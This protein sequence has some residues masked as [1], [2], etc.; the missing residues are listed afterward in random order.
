MAVDLFNQTFAVTCLDFQP[1]HCL[2]A[3]L[4]PV[5]L[6]TLQL[7]KKYGIITTHWFFE[8]YRKATYW[9]SVVTGYD[10]FFAIQR[11]PIEAACA[12]SGATYHFLPTACSCADLPFTSSPRPY[13][14]VFIGIPSSYRVAVLEAL[15]RNGTKLAIAGSGWQAYRGILEPM[16]VSTAWVHEE[17]SFALMQQSKTGVNLS[18]DNP[19]GRKDV[20]ISPRVYDMFA[21]GCLV[22]GEDV[23]LLNETAPGA[24]VATFSS[25]EEAVS[26]IAG[27]LETYT[28]DDE[29]ILKNRKLVLDN[30]RYVHRVA[31]IMRAAV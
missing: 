29:R 5:T 24:S 10:H 26:T 17:T 20:H 8:D 6:F 19:A 18:F 1:T 21:A 2:V 23:P 11:G 15:A 31:E 30:H 16:I 14:S 27:L 28:Y 13:D 3:A 22:A 4:A 7:L 9:E 12:A 25:S